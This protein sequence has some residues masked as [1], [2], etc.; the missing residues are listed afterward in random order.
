MGRWANV[1]GRKKAACR[2]MQTNS[3]DFKGR[4]THFDRPYRR[5]ELP[6]WTGSIECASVRMPVTSPPSPWATMPWNLRLKRVFRGEVSKVFLALQETLQNRLGSKL[7]TTRRFSIQMA[8]L[9]IWCHRTLKRGLDKCSPALK[10][11]TCLQ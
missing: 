10:Y 11:V 2:T 7:I 8:G 6:F 5:P 1:T 3:T 9:N 4:S